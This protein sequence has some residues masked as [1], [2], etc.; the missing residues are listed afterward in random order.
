M[1]PACI[2]LAVVGIS[3][4][5]TIFIVVRGAVDFARATSRDTGP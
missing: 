2:L 1:I 5:I 3:T 4:A